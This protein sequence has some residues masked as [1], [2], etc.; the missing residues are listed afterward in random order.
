MQLRLEKAE[1]G[2]DGQIILLKREVNG[3]KAK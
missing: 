2:K 1:A 3:L